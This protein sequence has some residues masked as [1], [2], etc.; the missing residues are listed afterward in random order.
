MDD[1][2]GENQVRLGL[3]AVCDLTDCIENAGSIDGQIVLCVKRTADGVVIISD[4]S[5]ADECV[6]RTFL[7]GDNELVGGEFENGRAFRT[8]NSDTVQDQMN[9]VFFGYL[10]PDLA[11]PGAA[12]DICPFGGNG[13]DLVLTAEAVLVVSQPVRAGQDN[14]HCLIVF[15]CVIDIFVLI[16]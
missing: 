7:H 4:R 1:G 10:D 9:L 12:E 15:K 14:V 6:F 3:N 11:V 5:P 13:Q 2:T 16:I 8:L